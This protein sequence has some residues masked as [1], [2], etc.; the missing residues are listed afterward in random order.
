MARIGED[1]PMLAGKAKRGNWMLAGEL[2]RNT[3]AFYKD[4][5]KKFKARERAA[6]RQR[7]LM[8]LDR[9]KRSTKKRVRRCFSVLFGGF[10]ELV[11]VVLILTSYTLALLKLDGLSDASWAAV[12]MPLIVL[13]LQLIF[14]IFLHS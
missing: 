5:F 8:A 2:P 4:S 3:R 6:A 1:V 12:F 7:R 10:A 9:E 14:G 11:T 13:S